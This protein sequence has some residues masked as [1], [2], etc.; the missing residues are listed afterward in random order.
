MNQQVW[1]IPNPAEN[2][3]RGENSLVSDDNRARGVSPEC[4]SLYRIIEHVEEKKQWKSELLFTVSE[5]P[6]G[7]C[8]RSDIL[9][10]TD[11]YMKVKPTV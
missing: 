10:Y 8:S 5:T 6:N 1:G 3:D 9:Q 4:D 11:S 7:P 2:V